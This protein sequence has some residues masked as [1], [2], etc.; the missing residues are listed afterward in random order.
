VRVP[1]RRVAALGF[2]GRYGGDIPAHKRN[3]LMFLTRLAGLSPRSEVWFAG[4]DGP[5]T[6]PLLRRNEVLV[7]LED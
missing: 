2:S 5:S 3:E 6:L 7:E 4:Y 1:A